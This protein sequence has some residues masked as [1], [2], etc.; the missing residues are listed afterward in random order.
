MRASLPVRL[1]H[2]IVPAFIILCIAVGGLFSYDGKKAEASAFPGGNGNSSFSS[3][4]DGNFEIYAMNVDDSG[5]TRLT[6]NTADDF[7]PAWSPDGTKIAFTSNR[8][9]NYDTYSMNTD[10]SGQIDLSLNASTDLHPD[11]QPILLSQVPTTK[12]QCKNGGWKSLVDV[13][14]HS[15]K[16]QGR[17]IQF[18]N[19]G[20]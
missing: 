17:C 9:G 6:T 4:R 14:G 12:D 20:H 18:V 5:Q 1:S 7:E 10:G 16:N 3:D 13:H 8:D 2:L 19:N 11:W 15:F